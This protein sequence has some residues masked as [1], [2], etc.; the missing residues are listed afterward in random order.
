MIGAVREVHC[1]TDRPIWPQGV[2]RPPDTPPCPPH[3]HWDLW[4]GPAPERP[5]HPIYHPFRW[6]GWWDFGTG[7]LG[8]MAC[9]CMDVLFWSLRL[10]APL[11][12]EA[13]CDAHYAE[14]APKWSIIR[15]EF[16]ARGDL[17]PV[18]LTW[19]DGG[20]YPPAELAEGEKYPDNGTLFIGEKGKLLLM[21]PY[22][23]SSKLLPAAQFKDF[24]PPAPYIPRSP[25]HHAEWIQG[26]KTGSP[27]GS[28]FQYAAAL[29]EMVLLGN[30]ALRVGKKIEWDAA[31]MKAKNCP[32]ADQY[33][34]REY[35]K[36]WSL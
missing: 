19:Y 13:E 10:G 17:P 33:L 27:T 8:D 6:R 14:T 12:V 23:G 7:A 20:K 22:G 1:W 28:N 16:P 4:L 9:H 32:E 11:T 18:K 36:G 34:R 30:V 35:R 2:N 15:Y 5:Y 25:G 26:C 21:D 29:T 31:N 24:S 3:I